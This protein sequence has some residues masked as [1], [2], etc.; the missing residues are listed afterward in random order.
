MDFLVNEKTME[1]IIFVLDNKLGK[2]YNNEK[3]K[4]LYNKIIN[5]KKER[6]LYQDY[7]IKHKT[8][9]FDRNAI[10]QLKLLSI[11]VSSLHEENSL[12]SEET[13]QM[14]NELVVLAEDI[15]TKYMHL[16]KSK[17][18]HLKSKDLLPIFL[19]PITTRN[20]RTDKVIQF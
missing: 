10:V 4:T 13:Q 9:G 12:P 15:E 18:L 6:E 5:L 8:Y 1:H 3:M 17:R 16:I 11:M 7:S 20:K 19:H 14:Y 2:S